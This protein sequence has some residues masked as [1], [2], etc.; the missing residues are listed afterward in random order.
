MATKMLRCPTCN[1]TRRMKSVRRGTGNGPGCAL[2]V[3]GLGLGVAGLAIWPLLVF[4]VPC[5]IAGL[6]VG[7]RVERSWR[8]PA[9]RVEVRRG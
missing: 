3:L 5:I 9:C 8:C 4:A 1:A 2:I 6:A 7:S